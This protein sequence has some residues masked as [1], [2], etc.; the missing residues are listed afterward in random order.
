M[1]AFPKLGY[2]KG[3]NPVN[4]SVS[5]AR[6]PKPKKHQHEVHSYQCAYY[7]RSSILCGRARRGLGRAEM[8]LLQEFWLGREAGVDQTLRRHQLQRQVFLAICCQWNR[9]YQQDLGL[10]FLYRPVAGFCRIIRIDPKEC[11]ALADVGWANRAASVQPDD[12]HCFRLFY[13]NRCRGAS[14]AKDAQSNHNDDL[15]RNFMRGQARSINYRDGNC[16]DV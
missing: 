4:I 9:S 2:K 5:N 7:R 1:L 13:D 15:G 11:F 14:L 3:D 8:R 10:I 6:S 16:T 12:E